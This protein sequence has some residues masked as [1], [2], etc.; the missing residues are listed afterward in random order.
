MP[1]YNLHVP[2]IVCTGCADTLITGL[3]NTDEVTDVQVDVVEKIVT[4]TTDKDIDEQTLIKVVKNRGHSVSSRSSTHTKG[5]ISRWVKGIVG[6]VAGAALLALSFISMGII[7]LYA[8]YIIGGISTLLTLYIGKDTYYNA[9]VNTFKNKTMSMDLLF[10]ISALLAIGVSLAGF[11]F[12]WLP[13]MFDAA[14]LILGFKHIGKAIEESIKQK[15]SQQNFRGR[16]DKEIEVL[17]QKNKVKIN[18][19]TP[20]AIIVVRSRQTIPLNGECQETISLY[21]TLINGRTEPQLFEKG[22]PV[23]AGMVVPASVSAIAIKVTATEEKSY[24]VE[25]DNE[26]KTAQLNKSP[27]ESTAN[28]MLKYFIPLVFLIA[29]ISAT[30]VALTISPIAAIQCAVSVLVAACPCT[31]GLVTPLAMRL[32]IAKG[33]EQGIG[34]KSGKSLEEAQQ[35]D[36]VVFDLTGTL[37]TGIPRVTTMDIPEHL[38]SHLAAVERTSTHPIAKA[39]CEYINKQSSTKRIISSVL[40]VDET[41]HS[42]RKAHFDNTTLLVGNES[43]MKSQGILINDTYQNILN[44]NSANHVS[45]FAVNQNIVGYA[46]LE[47]PLRPD[48]K[49]VIDKLKAMGKAVHLCT[50]A[51]QYTAERYAKELG[52]TEIYADCPSANAK[53]EYILKLRDQHNKKVAMIGDAGNDVAAIAASHFGI[54]IQSAAGDKITQ[55]K[56]GAVISKDASLWSVVNAF[57]IANQTVSKIKQNLVISLAYNMLAIAAFSCVLVALGIF[58]HPAIGAGLMILQTAIVLGNTTSLRAGETVSS[59]LQD[60]AAPEK[61]T[62]WIATPRDKACAAR[63]DETPSLRGCAALSRS[64]PLDTSDIEV[65]RLR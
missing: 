26:I 48:A 57:E 58:V 20:G 63:K 10:A 53:K 16:V 9:I 38:L 1:I 59:S 47:D 34:F 11:A 29:I 21:T 12:P 44:N 4:I 13:M 56:A 14:L 36:T 27:L 30:I 45:F 62:P 54:A 50:G 23:L 32:G 49:S 37:T 40:N 19:I 46:Q 60:S 43:F 22:K 25:L 51:D 65:P 33:K 55:E 39:L 61:T 8:M 2:T 18:T 28:K 17:G 24:L 5:I 6:I 3:K 31:F 41:S 42:G 64:N 35:A 7:P 52:I 15:V